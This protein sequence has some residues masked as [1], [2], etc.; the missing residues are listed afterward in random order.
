MQATV[1]LDV[2]KQKKSKANKSINCA[3]K[4]KM[5]TPNQHPT[6]T[7]PVHKQHSTSTQTALNQYATSTQP[8]TGRKAQQNTAEISVKKNHVSKQNKKPN[9]TVATAIV[10]LSRFRYQ[11]IWNIKDDQE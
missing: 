8:V 2:Q 3:S 7:Q 6:S 4:P 11:H 9:D 1:Y 10:R 5:S